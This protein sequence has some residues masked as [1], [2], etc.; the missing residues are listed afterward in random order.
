MVLKSIGTF[1]LDDYEGA[2]NETIPIDICNFEGTVY[3]A[4]PQGSD[5]SISW[6]VTC[7]SKSYSGS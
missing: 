3:N 2:Y 1:S 5:A 7:D 6:T 4:V